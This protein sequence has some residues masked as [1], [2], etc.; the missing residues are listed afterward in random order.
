[1]RLL[2]D[3]LKFDGMIDPEHVAAEPGEPGQYDAKLVFLVSSD[4]PV[5]AEWGYR[6]LNS[7]VQEFC[8]ANKEAIE[9]KAWPS[10]KTSLS[11]LGYEHEGDF[12]ADFTWAEQVDYL[13]VVEA[14]GKIKFHV[15][16]ALDLERQQD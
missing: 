14:D 9:K 11:Y 8:D 12:L 3:T 16:M 2:L 1:M 6:Q 15:D 5:P 10:L 4:E 7:A 13:V